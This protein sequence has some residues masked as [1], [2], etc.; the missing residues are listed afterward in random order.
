MKVTKRILSITIIVLMICSIAVMG[1]V[2]SS[3]S[4]TGTGLAEWALNAYY[5]NW[6][7]VYGGAS[8]GAVDCSG[9]IYSYAGGNRTGD[10]QLYSSSYVGYVSNGVP[11]I[12]GLGL[13]KPGHVGVYVG[14]DMAVDARGSQWGVCYESVYSHGWTKY[15]KVSGVSYPTTG[16]VKF[17]GD[18]YYYEN[19]QYLASTTRTIDG[20]SYTFSSSGKCSSN[21]SVA[22][23]NSSTSTDSSVLK[24]GS[25]GSAVEKLQKRL[26]ELGYYT[27]AIDG[28]FGKGTEEAFKLF[29]KQAGLYVD[30]IAGS[31]AD[32]LYSDDAPYYVAQEEETQEVV[33]TTKR[34]NEIAQTS[35]QQE[36]E[37]EEETPDSFAKGDYHEKIK[38]IQERLSSLGYYEGTADGSFGSGTEEAVKNFQGA[39][40]IT[41]TGVADSFTLEM[42]FSN[43][44]TENPIDDTEE[45][46]Q[47]E[48]VESEL[49][50]S[51]LV[52]APTVA[53]PT[54]AEVTEVA[55]QTNELSEK[56]LAGI[57][58]SI[59]FEKDT[60][61]NNFQFIFWLLVMIVV[62]TISFAIIK[63]IEKKKQGKTKSKAA[64]RYF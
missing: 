17:N 4:G 6:S 26:A 36:K 44:A 3:A 50:E 31:D 63:T 9:L 12:H 64:R 22:N 59:G 58:N 28:D 15:F 35:A 46:T 51:A 2:S 52:I 43:L 21:E 60:N 25:T 57:A 42:L 48:V 23:S 13:W 32:Y 41:Q 49:P 39:N 61:G 30:G 24:K 11:R 38:D 29:Q 56:A 62:M 18:K 37:V 45:E 8:A 40:G 5:S 16:W 54:E 7:Y 20:V 10:A 27:G 47:I 19:G 14:A 55:L 1:T 33:V 53:Q 34:E